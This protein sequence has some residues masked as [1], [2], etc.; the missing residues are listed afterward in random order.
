MESGIQDSLDYL[1]WGEFV[2]FG[3][4]GQS[5]SQSGTG[6]P[7]FTVTL[8]SRPDWPLVSADDFFFTIFFFLWGH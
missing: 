1:T 5:V 2:V 7:I 8:M 6:G 4:D 3:D